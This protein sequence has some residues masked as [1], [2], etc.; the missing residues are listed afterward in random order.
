MIFH[1]FLITILFSNH[2]P[3]H[4][5]KSSPRHY[6]VPVTTSQAA[7]PCFPHLSHAFW[8]ITQLPQPNCSHLQG[9]AWSY[10]F[11][12]QGLRPK[13]MSAG[14]FHLTVQMARKWFSFLCYD[15]CWAWKV[16]GLFGEISLIFTLGI[17]MSTFATF[18]ACPCAC[19][20]VFRQFVWRMEWK[21]G[22]CPFSG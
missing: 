1:I 2:L 14:S 20:T 10:Q 22:F 7:A 5:P 19:G 12:H 4:P 3:P 21:W 18:I 9:T 13:S 6:L 16:V 11:Y 8:Q 17:K 15:W